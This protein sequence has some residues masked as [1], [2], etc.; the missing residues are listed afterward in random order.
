ML[1]PAKLSV[2][3]SRIRSFNRISR[4]YRP[5][6]LLD[7]VGNRALGNV[8]SAGTHN[9]IMFFGNDHLIAFNEIFNV[10]TE[11]D[12]VGA[13]YTGRDWTARGTII[14][15]NYLHDIRRPGSQG[16]MGVY[17]DDQASGMKVQGNLFVRVDQ[18]VI[19]GGGRDNVVEDNL[20]VLS[21]PAVHVDA[22][23]LTYQKA[24]TEDPQG[25]LRMQLARIPFDRPPYSNRYP[26]LATILQ[27]EP[28]APKYN[29]I[30]RNIVV[31]SKPARLTEGA[32]K[33]VRIESMIEAGPTL[34][35]SGEAA[36]QRSRPFDFSISRSAHP[37]M[38]SFAPLPLDL[39]DC[40]GSSWRL[41]DKG[42]TPP[43]CSVH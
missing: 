5:A 4:T 26:N 15:N 25:Q 16:S 40:V 20:F 12:D 31:D 1:L 2:E 14:R 17:L 3:N 24:L 41:R 37:E 36:L 27:D 19:I 8:I 11:T 23:G 10:A 39:M 9:A 21:S 22:R 13:I 6:V 29:V 32:E 38:G 30:R 42:R 7:G 35:Q 28:G 18:P 43:V 33:W 34:F